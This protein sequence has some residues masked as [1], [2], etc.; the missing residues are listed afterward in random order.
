MIKMFYTVNPAMKE[1]ELQWLHDQKVYPACQNMFDWKTN[2]AV[3]GFGVIVNPETALAI[4]LRHKLDM[5][6][7][8]KQR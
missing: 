3:I 5:Q 2:T 4:K 7:E 6:A 1:I 8:Y